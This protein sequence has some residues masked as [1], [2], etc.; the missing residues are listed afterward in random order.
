MEKPT[1]TQ[2]NS[3]RLPRALGLIADVESELRDAAWNSILLGET[4]AADFV[5]F[6]EDETAQWD[7]TQE[8]VAAAFNH[9]LAARRAQQAKWPSEQTSLATAFA[10]LNQIGVIARQN[11]SCC[12]TCASTEIWDEQDDSQPWRGYVYF[13]RQDTE[14]LI[15]TRKTYL[16]Y[17]A[18]VR[19]W[20]K[21]DQWVDLDETS[22]ETRYQE[23]VRKLLLNE[24]IPVLEKHGMTVTWDLD[25]GKRILVENA[26]FRALV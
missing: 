21:E 12:G 23:I 16:G 22:R 15:E 6:M 8:T 4:D 7:I 26:D 13:H 24:V 1:N 9:V 2:P 14:G 20:I 18:F 25:L 5:D 10:E 19:S 11:F 3:L 17:G